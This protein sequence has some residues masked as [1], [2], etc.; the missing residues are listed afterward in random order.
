MPGDGGSFWYTLGRTVEAASALLAAPDAARPARARARAEPPTPRDARESPLASLVGGAVG[1]LVA[2][3][4]ARIA[5]GRRPTL[6]R[7]VR[8][9][10]AGAGAAGILYAARVLLDREDDLAADPAGEAADEILAGA[11]RGV[12]YAAVLDPF[13]PGPPLVRGAMAGTVDY[14]AAPL[15]GIF[16]RLQPL[17]PVRRVPVLSIL[18]ET[19]DA[20]D[21]PYLTF[22]LHGALLGLLYGEPRDGDEG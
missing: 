9:A 10:A 14:F 7:L 19:G 6:G 8:G 11:G 4:A 5:A 17:S 12:L 13:L 3:A 15:G 2:T 22:L 21:D 18:L 16:S 20:E 1:A